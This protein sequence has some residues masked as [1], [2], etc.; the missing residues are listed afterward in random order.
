VGIS[1]VDVAGL[2]VVMQLHEALGGGERIALVGASSAVRR[3][4]YLLGIEDRFEHVGATDD[5]PGQ[6]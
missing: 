3:L 6:G 1:F 5:D 2:E 4:L